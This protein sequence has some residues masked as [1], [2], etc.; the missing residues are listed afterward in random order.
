ML[1]IKQGHGF[2]VFY[3]GKLFVAFMFTE[4]SRWLH[5]RYRFITDNYKDD[6]EKH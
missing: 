1:K 2:P 6:D 5:F 3:L 4:L